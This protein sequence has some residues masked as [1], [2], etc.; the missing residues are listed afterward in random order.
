MLLNLYQLFKRVIIIHCFLSGD[1]VLNQDV[2]GSTA[3]VI[4]HLDTSSPSLENIQVGESA[5][6]VQCFYCKECNKLFQLKSELIEHQRWHSSEKAFFCK[7]CNQFLN[8]TSSPWEHLR[9]MHSGEITLYKLAEITF[10]SNPVDQS[11]KNIPLYCPECN[12]LCKCNSELKRHRRMHTGE[13]PFRCEECNKR[14]NYKSSL[15]EHF[16]VHSGEKPYV[17]TECNKCFR[18]GSTLNRHK[19]THT[20]EKPHK[21]EVC[22]KC[23]SARK[24]LKEHKVTHSFKQSFY[25]S[26]CHQYF[27]RER[28]LLRHNRKEHSDEEQAHDRHEDEEPERCLQAG[29]GLAN[30]N[31]FQ[32]VKS[33]GIVVKVEKPDD[34]AMSLEMLV[35]SSD[36]LNDLNGEINRDATE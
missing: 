2:Q 6:S 19:K 17:C 4:N 9:T 34:E 13:R 22:G 7:E 26:K 24:G 29:G 28:S 18:Q 14:F 3:N 23:F 11:S 5:N 12:K 25:C 36:L 33:A 30:G 35:K 8:C 32:Q 15:L 10:G 16:R 1:S 31:E 20:G 21:C 27:V